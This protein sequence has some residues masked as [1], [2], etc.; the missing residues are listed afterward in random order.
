MNRFSF[1]LIIILALG[2]FFRFYSLGSFP[3]SLHRDEAFLGYNAYSLLKTGMDMSGIFLPIHTESF[4]YS[5]VGYSYLSIPFIYVFGLSEFS[6]RFVSALFGS[7]TI[8]VVYFFVKELFIHGTMQ[9]KT[10]KHAE[11]VALL[12][13]FVLA[14][15]P[16]HIN[17]SRTATENII[18]T[19]FIVAGILFYL[20]S[21]GKRW[22]YL[23]ISFILF[24]A[25]LF[26]YQ[27]PRAFLPVFIPIMILVFNNNINLIKNKII[28]IALYLAFIIVPL[29]FVLISPQLSLRIRTLSIFH[30][31]L[32]QLVINEQIANDGSAGL[33]YMV[34][35]VFHN[36]VIGYGNLFIENYFKHFS[37]DFL[38]LDK[39]YPDRYRVP[40]MGLLYIFQLP[41]I[42]FGA[43]YLINKHRK[44]GIFVVSWILVS[45]IGSALTFD[46]VPNLQRTVFVIPAYSILSAFGLL[47]FLKLARSFNLKL[48][49]PAILA[50]IFVI[51]FS[52]SYYLVQYYF[53]ARVYRSWYRQDGYKELVEK[54]NNLLPNYKKAVVTNRESAPTIFFLFYSKYNPDL[55]QKTAKSSKLRDF[56]RISFDKYIFSEDECPLRNIK[57]G[58]I[59]INTREKDTLYVNSGLCKD[60]GSISKVLSEIKRIDS[61][62][63][64]YVS[65]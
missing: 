20:M 28:L 30:D 48:F 11:I 29:V 50:C 19:F 44:I 9:I 10:L 62:L 3:I 22:K 53:Q 31:N 60:T 8:V 6:V 25:T 40:G 21:V 61:S 17:L 1:T 59:I 54:V 38:F 52:I 36:K 63:V 18:V 65:E 34:T 58:N 37:F 43:I 12:S 32:T 16:W 51:A 49:K 56:D 39:G 7:A 13:S 5:P 26:I 4:L 42:V 24:S 45:P 14:I 23:V 47:I 46:D 57:Q 15:S 27:S 64:F 55:F 35:R 33:P 2:I 41:L